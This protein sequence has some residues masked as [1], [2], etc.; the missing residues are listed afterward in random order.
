M[1][2]RLGV[3]G[4]DHLHLF[5]LVQGLLDAGAE[6]TAHVADGELL[7]LYEDWRDESVATEL[8]TMLAEFDIDVVVTAAVPSQRADIAVAALEAGKHVLSAKP[9][10]TTLADLARVREAVA[11]SGHRWVVLFTER[12]ENRAV[13]EAVRLA[14]DGAIGRVV[15]VVGAGPHAFNREGRPEWFFDPGR[16][17]GILA[18]L[19]SHQ[20]DQFLAITGADDAIVAASAVGN[21]SCPEH[22]AMQDVGSMRLL[23]GGAVGDHRVDLLSPAGLGTWGD[24]RLHVVGTE[25]TLEV[26][27][28]IDPAGQPGAEHLIVV[29]AEGT[30]R[31]DCSNVVLDWAERFGADLADGTETL[32][33]QHHVV[34]V[35]RLT[36][37][38]QSQATNWASLE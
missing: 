29:D 22:P 5:G 37:E 8:P 10:V 16:S 11:A 25:G 3:A 27:A 1:G 14:T 31:V 17:G 38:A 35:C 6:T 21:V 30:R 15:H 33:T 19:A 7:G 13:A 36:L 12:F 4:I 32:M 18:D 28:N 9:G 2:L 23:G 24:T 34:D 20:A 26:R